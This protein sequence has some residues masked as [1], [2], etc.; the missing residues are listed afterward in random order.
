[1]FTDTTILVIEDNPDH[2][3]L[4]E[5][6]IS[7]ASAEPAFRWLSEARELVGIFAGSGLHTRMTA[8]PTRSPT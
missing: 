3:G 8:E 2:V 6:V 4:I 5:A 1:M 7:A